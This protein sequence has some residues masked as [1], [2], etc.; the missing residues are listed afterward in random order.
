MG[1][2]LPVQSQAEAVFPDQRPVAVDG[3]QM[4]PEMQ[5]LSSPYGKIENPI[6]F[7]ISCPAENDEKNF[8][9]IFGGND[10]EDPGKKHVW[11]SIFR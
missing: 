8:G 6:Q 4:T 1:Q 7:S 10:G 2:T 9:R 11:S 5:D 3:F